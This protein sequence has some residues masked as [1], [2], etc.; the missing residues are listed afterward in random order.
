MAVGLL[1]LP[2]LG[3]AMLP[4]G[5][6]IGG[7]VEAARASRARSAVPHHPVHVESADR[8]DALFERLGYDLDAVA[9]GSAPVPPVVLASLPPDLAEATPVDRRKALFIRAALPIVMAAN[10]AVLEERAGLRS[11]LARV[12]AGRRIPRE[13]RHRFRRT[14]ERYGLADLEAEPAG[15]RRLLR[16]VDAVPVSLALAQ[17]IS[18]SGWG[19]SRFALAGN[20]LFGQWTW[21]AAAGM[22][23]AARPAG[24]TH[25]V[26]AFRT[27][28]DSARAYL[29]NLNTHPAYA[30]LREARAAARRDHGTLPAGEDLA[31]ALTRYSE[32]GDAY[33][34]DIVALIRQNRLARLDEATLADARRYAT[35]AADATIEG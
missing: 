33:V 25:R 1:L 19:S 12:E 16:R 31:R 30:A 4:P 5:S 11:L 23:P 6:D 29:L 26:R 32:R 20:A 17:A 22:V 35:A 10:A 3:L 21:D 13:L 15:I 9:E 2:L 28:G 24:A 7:I 34:A 14:A 8:L 27:L 18:E